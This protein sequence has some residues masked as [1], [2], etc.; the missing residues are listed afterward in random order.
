[1]GFGV[2]RGH[3]DAES[4]FAFGDDGETETDDENSVWEE[5]FGHCDRC[6]GWAD[7]DRA[8]RGGGFEDFELGVLFD[9]LAAVLRD[10]TEFLDTLGIVHERADRGVGARGDGYREGVGEEGWASAL[11]DEVDEVLGC[12]DESACAASESFAEGAGEDIDLG[13]ALIIEHVVVFVS[14][15]SGFS[16]DAVGVGVVD[17]E[18]G[19]VLIAE[20]S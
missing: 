4:C 12:G 17:A 2:G 6:F 16:E 7:N 15:S 1:M 10:V 14:S 11:D 8:D 19:T 13:H 9:L 5:L 18:V 20:C 3:L